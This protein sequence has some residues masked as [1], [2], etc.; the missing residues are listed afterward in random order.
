MG[1]RFTAES[2]QK[3]YVIQK[4]HIVWFSTRI[5]NLKKFS[6]CFSSCMYFEFMEYSVC[7]V[8]SQ[9]QLSRTEV[10]ELLILELHCLFCHQ[11]FFLL[12]PHH[13]KQRHDACNEN[14]SV[15]AKAFKNIAPESGY[16]WSW[17][18]V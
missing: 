15:D 8:L 4:I 9:Y 1:E 2:R 3:F 6:A 17:S 7:E 5:W 14:I 13:A 18:W 12:Y 11:R 10:E 16:F